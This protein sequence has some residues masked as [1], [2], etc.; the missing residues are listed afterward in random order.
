MYTRPTLWGSKF[1]DNGNGELLIDEYVYVTGYV[2]KMNSNISISL[3]VLTVVLLLFRLPVARTLKSNDISFQ[4]LNEAASRD[5]VTHLHGSRSQ[6]ADCVVLPPCRCV[7]RSNSTHQGSP[8]RVRVA[9]DSTQ[10]SRRRVLRFSK[11]S[12]LTRS[13]DHLSLAYAGLNALPAATFQ[14][15]EVTLH[16]IIHL[17]SLLLDVVLMM[18]L[19]RHLTIMRR[20]NDPLC[21]LCKEEEE[22]RLHFLGKCCATANNTQVAFWCSFSGT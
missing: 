17:A 16:G 2:N 6:T 15:I 5:V 14:H 19:N 21:P 8:S 12:V 13:F 4:L 1:V 20:L 9:C 18:T 22:T 3:C 10:T 7:Q 11:S